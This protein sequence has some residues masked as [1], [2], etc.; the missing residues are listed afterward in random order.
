MPVMLGALAGSLLGARELVGAKTRT[1]RIVFS[2]VI[3]ALAIE[4]IYNGLTGR[5]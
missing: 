4:R 5:L 1:L 2:V 3:I